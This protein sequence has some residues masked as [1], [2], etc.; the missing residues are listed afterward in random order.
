MHLGGNMLYLYIFGDNTENMCGHISYLTFYL[1][2]GTLA[3]LALFVSDPTPNVPAIGASGA[4]SGILGSYVLLFPRVRILT[5]VPIGFFVVS[6]PAFV[7]IGFWFVYQ[8][9]LAFLAVE[10]G[11]AC[12]AHIGGFIAGLALGKVFARRRKTHPLH[13]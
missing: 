2:C 6:I 4:I 13:M 9:L 5:A 7:T 8:F 3:S 1:A 10:T 11:V 12:W